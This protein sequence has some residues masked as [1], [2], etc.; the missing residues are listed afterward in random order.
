MAITRE[1][2]C[3][4]PFVGLKN[5]GLVVSNSSTLVSMV[6]FA[7]WRNGVDTQL[8][9][10]AGGFDR[11]DRHRSSS[12]KECKGFDSLGNCSGHSGRNPSGSDKA[13]CL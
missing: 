6:D 8:I 2:A 5:A 13:V 1:S 11:T 7:Q 12:Y 10:G 3:L 4:S 9:C